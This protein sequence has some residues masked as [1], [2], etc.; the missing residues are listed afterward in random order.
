[1]NGAM[2]N[3]QMKNDSPNYSQLKAMLAITMASLRSITRSPSAVVFTLAFPLIF[4]IV[5]GFIGGGGFAVDV[6]MKAG[7][8]KNNPI[9][10]ALKNI[11]VVHIDTALS[12]DEIRNNLEKGRI[13][14]V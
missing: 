4:I 9:Y 3:Q 2:N 5:F 11:S 1:M 8:D 7:S 13:D 14:A 10:T 6:A 12:M